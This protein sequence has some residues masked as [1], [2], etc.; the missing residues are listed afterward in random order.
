MY[1]VHVELITNT[2]KVSLY[3][4]IRKHSIF[5]IP[6]KYAI[7]TLTVL[8]SRYHGLGRNFEVTYREGMQYSR[9]PPIDS[10]VI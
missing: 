9:E 4:P 2:M 1:A 6:D 7:I 8:M 3:Y 5:W 10:W